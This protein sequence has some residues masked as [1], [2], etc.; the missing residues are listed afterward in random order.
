MEGGV[1]RSIGNPHPQRLPLAVDKRASML[2]STKA[3]YA[4]LG[5][6]GSS[7]VTSGSRGNLRSA[8][9]ALLSVKDLRG[10]EGAVRLS[11]DPECVGLEQVHPS[12]FLQDVQPCDPEPFTSGASLDGKSGLE[13][14]LPTRPNQ[15]KL[16]QVSSPD[17]LGKA[18][19]FSSPAIRA[20]SS[21]LAVLRP[22]RG[23]LGAPQGQRVE[24]PGIHRR[25]GTMEPEQGRAAGSGPRSSQ[26]AEEVGSDRKREEIASFSDLI[27]GLGRG[28]LGLSQGYMVPTTQ[29]PG[30][31]PG[32]CNPLASSQKGLEKAMGKV[33]RPYRLRVSDKSKSQALQSSSHSPRSLQPGPEQRRG[34]RV[35]PSSSRGVAS[36]D[37]GGCMDV[38]RLLCPSVKD[39]PNLVRCVFDGL[40]RPYRSGSVPE[41]SLVGGAKQ[42]AYKCL[43]A[44]DHS[45][46]VEGNSTPRHLASSLVRQPDSHKGHSEAGLSLSRST[47]ARGPTP[48]DLRG[49]EDPSHPETH[50]GVI[51]CSSRRPLS[52]GSHPGRMGIERGI[53]Q[54]SRKPTRSI[55]A[56]GSVRFAAQSQASGLLLP[57]QLSR[58]AAGCSSTGLEPVQSSADLPSSESRKGGGQEASVLQ[59]GGVLILP[60]TP[61]IL[62]HFPSRLFAKELSMR[63]PQQRLAERTILAS[64][65]FDHFRAWSF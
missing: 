2:S 56:G 24:D 54:E 47:K 28:S 42:M 39:S 64:E 59:G 33:V 27:S 63:P 38:P 32:N 52:R 16:A 49:E 41:R 46:G 55:A 1:I 53:V 43:G 9:S 3:G 4:E 50:Q 19:L 25:F 60:D 8:A 57:I 12:S 13:G 22:D 17:V 5:G 44:S 48:R 20:S 58:S 62:R 37:R 61:A 36:L 45:S 15:A 29:N 30:G 40:G 21:T 10:P 6:S 51:E 11:S 14:R 65:G 18:V 26:S 7:P 23:G 31:D 35:P 34:G